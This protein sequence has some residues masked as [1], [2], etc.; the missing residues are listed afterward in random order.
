MVDNAESIGEDGE[1]ISVADMAVDILL[2]H[3]GAGSGL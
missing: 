2:F 1:F 3:I